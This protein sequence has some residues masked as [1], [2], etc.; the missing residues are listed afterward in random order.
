VSDVEKEPSVAIGHVSLRVRDPEEAARFYSKLGLKHVPHGGVLEIME[1]RGGT[2]LMLFRARG[3]PRAGPIRSFDF[4]VD[5]LEGRRAELVAAGVP[6]TELHEDRWSN[7][8]CFEVTD[9]DGHV[10]SFVSSHDD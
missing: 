10:L 6:C 5:D 9:P 8:R 3:K 4:L 7:H 1:L 2:H